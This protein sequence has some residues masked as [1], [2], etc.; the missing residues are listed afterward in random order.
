[1]QRPCEW[2]ALWDYTRG[3]SVTVLLSSCPCLSLDGLITKS[4]LTW[5]NFW[6]RQ[7][8]WSSTCV[9]FGVPLLEPSV[10]HV[11][12][13]ASH[14]E[15]TMQRCKLPLW[16]SPVREGEGNASSA[17]STVQFTFQSPS[18]Q[19]YLW[20]HSNQLPFPGHST[21]HSLLVPEGELIFQ[22]SMAGPSV[23]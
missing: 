15:S 23:H 7:K 11:S 1:M 13:L 2:E 12:K 8:E 5:H 4:D 18:C 19:R 10:C 16:Q 17:S 22:L 14:P 20:H 6:Y 3:T 9:V 21:P